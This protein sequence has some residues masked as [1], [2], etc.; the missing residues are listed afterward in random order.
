MPIF[1]DIKIKLRTTKKKKFKSTITKKKVV[2]LVPKSITGDDRLIALGLLR[3][4]S[5]NTIGT[6]PKLY[7]TYSF[8]KKRVVVKNKNNKTIAKYKN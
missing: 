6:E 2:I 3:F 4:A 1:D 8:K 5:M 7:A